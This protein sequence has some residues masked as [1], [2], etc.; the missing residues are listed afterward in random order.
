MAY[1][2]VLCFML[3]D[4]APPLMPLAG[5]LWRVVGPLLLAVGSAFVAVGLA[6]VV[7][8]RDSAWPLWQF[9]AA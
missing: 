6:L 8:S 7:V 5:S 1:G 9:A 3:L 4:P 2:A